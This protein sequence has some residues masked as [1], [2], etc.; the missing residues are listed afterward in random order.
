MAFSLG[1]L[2]L[3]PA[4]AARADEPPGCAVGSTNILGQDKDPN[5]KGDVTI[6]C[7]G[8]TKAFGN[9]LTE[10]LNRIL[11]DRLDPRA[12]L[13]KL[14]EVD[15]VP[16]AGVARTSMRASVTR[17]FRA[18]PANPPQPSPSPP[19]R[20]SK[21]APNSPGRSPRRC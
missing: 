1:L 11:Q 13:A 6:N 19:I 8:L 4:N 18:S 3:P 9:R 15:A 21:T 20:R 7:T 5:A 16:A 14:A 2:V 17:S 10:V 12:V